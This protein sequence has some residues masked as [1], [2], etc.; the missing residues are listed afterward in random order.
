MT[1]RRGRRLLP[2]VAT[3][4]V[5]GG[6][7][8]L[9]GQSYAAV[10]VVTGSAYG[11]YSNVS[12]FGG[13]FVPKGPAP[14][15]TL[16][17]GGSTSG[18]TANAPSETAQYGPAVIFS[19]GSE[20]VTTKGTPAGGSVTSSTSILNAGGSP[21]TASKVTSTCTAKPTAVTGSTAIT[22]GK[23][24]TKTDANGNPVTTVS[25]PAKPA[26]NTTY[27][28]T[29]NNVGDSFRFVFNEQ[30]VHPDGSVTVNAG[31]EYLLGPTAKG[32]LIFGQSVCGVR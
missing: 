29:V 31:H 13:P 23:L 32:D 5:V 16:P 19:S 24:V 18:V 8:A 3:V 15:V 10:T 22:S 11:Y 26:R 9:S 2:W 27:T 1:I 30:V 12:L 4:T 17:P 7:F 28:G 14:R 20:T 21:F 6:F 25:I